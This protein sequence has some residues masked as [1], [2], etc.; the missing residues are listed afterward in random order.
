MILVGHSFGGGPT[1]EAALLAPER[2]QALV[3]VDAALNLQAVQSAPTEPP[4]FIQHFSAMRPL[5]NAMIASTITNPLFTRKLLQLMIHDPADATP[6]H[7]QMLQQ[8]LTLIGSTD[9]LGDW[10]LPFLTVTDTGLSS[11]PDAYQ[12]LTMPTL[13]IWG[14]R[15]TITPLAQGEYLQQILPNAKLVSLP[16]VG[17]IPHIEETTAFNTTLVRFLVAR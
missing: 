12:A 2:V 1:V 10:L 15:D 7:V 8:P 16:E 14:E 17:H 3:L 5:R 11:K 4:P 9:T 13:L 6:A